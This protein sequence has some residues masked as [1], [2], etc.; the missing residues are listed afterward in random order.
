ML[1]QL[2]DLCSSRCG[3]KGDISNVAVFAFD[4]QVFEA[5][6]E[7]LTE[8]RVAAQYGALVTGPVRRTVAPKVL[9]LNFVMYGAL[10]GGSSVTLR[11]DNL[12]KTM[13][14][15]MLRMAIELP[16]ELR[17]RIRPRPPAP[18]EFE[19]YLL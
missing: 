19:Q 13:S 14:T 16:D 11:S 12:G 7:Q 5:M 18:D 1:Y 15:P 3:D 2:R 6:L 10:G 9:G 4:E 8:E 17:V